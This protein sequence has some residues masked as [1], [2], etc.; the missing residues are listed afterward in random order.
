MA[1]GAC[2]H[3]GKMITEPWPGEPSSFMCGG[4]TG[5][6][7]FGLGPRDLNPLDTYHNLW[8]TGGMKKQT[9]IRLSPE[10]QELIRKLVHKLGIP[11]SDVLELAIRR[12]A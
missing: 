4:R 2:L 9:S 1:G 6:P 5:I 10:A 3:Q 8:Y 12:L 7:F 11:Q